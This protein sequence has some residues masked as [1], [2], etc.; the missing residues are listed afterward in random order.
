VLLPVWHQL[1]Y[2]HAAQSI[3]ITPPPTDTHNSLCLHLVSVLLPVSHQL[4]GDVMQLALQMLGGSLIH[5][6][7]QMRSIANMHMITGHATSR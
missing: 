6:R 3:A 2:K 5:S 7:L 4:G 1:L